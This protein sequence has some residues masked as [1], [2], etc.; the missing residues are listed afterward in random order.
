MKIFASVFFFMVIGTRLRMK[1]TVRN[2]VA[3]MQHFPTTGQKTN[4][5]DTYLLD[6]LIFL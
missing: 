3:N 5:D 4:S 6:L 1:K 2:Q